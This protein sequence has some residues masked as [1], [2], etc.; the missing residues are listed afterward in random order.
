MLFLHFCF[1]LNA[2][3][4]A[5]WIQ[6]FWFAHLVSAVAT[7]VILAITTALATRLLAIAAALATLDKVT[8]GGIKMACDATCNTVHTARRNTDYTLCRIR[9]GSYSI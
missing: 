8:N 2:K 4:V 3:R 7:G 9:Y 5:K 1:S 6:V